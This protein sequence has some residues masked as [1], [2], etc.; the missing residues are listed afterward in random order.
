M[1]RLSPKTLSIAAA[2]L[3]LFVPGTF[4]QDAPLNGQALGEDFVETARPNLLKELGLTR[5]QL[6]AIR[7]MNHSRRPQMAEAVRLLREAN[8]DLDTAIYA[9][10]LDETVVSA[11]LQV[12]QRAQN[13]VAKLRFEG[14][15]ALRRI[16]S[17]EQL[18]RFRALRD[19]FARAR[20]SR[21]N[22]R[23]NRPRGDRP[24]QRLRQLPRQG[25]RP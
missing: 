21:K 4:A 11:R 5:E 6:Q 1:C 2:L 19:D 8:R 7:R 12:L 22:L 15:L 9:D 23:R 14:E 10:T 17:P 13:D 16:L 3:F 24:L 25:S 20:E 18:R